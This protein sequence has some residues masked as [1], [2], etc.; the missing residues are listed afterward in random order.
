[1]RAGINPATPLTKRSMTGTQRLVTPFASDV[2]AQD[3]ILDGGNYL[4]TQPNGDSTSVAAVRGVTTDV[5]SIF[6]LE[7]QVTVQIDNFA[8]LLR[9]QITPILGS[10]VLDESFFAL[11][12]MTQAGV[13]NRVVVVDKSL[14]SA[15]LIEIK[16]DPVRADTFLASY[17]VGVFVS[18]ANGDIVIFI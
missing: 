9:V 16:E 12:S 8:R 3:V 15:R 7:E 17:N 11:Y 13:F 4:V 14:K 2:A 18:A 5:S 6:F 1:M 10:S